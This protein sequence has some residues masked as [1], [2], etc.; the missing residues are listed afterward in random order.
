LPKPGRS[1]KRPSR[2]AV[3]AGDIPTIEI[4]AFPSCL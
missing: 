2:V 4:M 1:G 3:I